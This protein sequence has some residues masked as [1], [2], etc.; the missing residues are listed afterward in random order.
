M[1]DDDEE[2]ALDVDG[3]GDAETY[4]RPQ[5]TEDDVR[6][7]TAKS[8]AGSRPASRGGRV[9]AGG[10]GGGRGG[11]GGPASVEIEEKDERSTSPASIE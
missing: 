8:G 3:D 10:V 5:F 2:V 11:D 7:V 9:D 6:R 4:G 1:V